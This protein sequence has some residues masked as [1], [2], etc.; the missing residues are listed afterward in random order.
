MSGINTLQSLEQIT[1][2]EFSGNA[3]IREKSNIYLCTCKE[4]FF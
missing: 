4:R 1:L 2:P 3:I